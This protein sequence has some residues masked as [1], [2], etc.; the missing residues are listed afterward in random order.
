LLIAE[1]TE[2]VLEE[3]GMFYHGSNMVVLD[4]PTENEMMLAR[5]IIDDSTLVI[6][7]GDSISIHRK[8]LIEEYSLAEGEPFTR[9][10]LKEIGT[11]L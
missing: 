5:D 2:D 6:R 8:G 9:V 1:Y 3:E 4:N 10:Y 11:V 7:K